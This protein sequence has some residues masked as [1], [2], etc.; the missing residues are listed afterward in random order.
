MRGTLW[1]GSDRHESI[2]MRIHDVAISVLTLKFSIQMW[3]FLLLTITL[4]DTL[5]QAG[6]SP[7]LYLKA[8]AACWWDILGSSLTM[9]LQPS[10]A[11]CCWDI[12]RFSLTMKLQ[13]YLSL[14]V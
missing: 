13:P 8:V 6:L 7:S 1:C 10:A 14:P 12:L 5:V 2:G 3:Y 4:R 11:V 9:K